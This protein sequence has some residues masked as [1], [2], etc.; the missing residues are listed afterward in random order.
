MNVN[1]KLGN[2]ELNL[3]CYYQPYEPQELNYPGCDESVTVEEV[4]FKG[5]D[6]TELLCEMDVDIDVLSEL[7]LSE[8]QS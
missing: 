6:V 7:A 8:I 2:L 4:V 5:I 1:I 3:E